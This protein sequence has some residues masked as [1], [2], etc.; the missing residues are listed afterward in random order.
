MLSFHISIFLFQ[1]D[2][3]ETSKLQ[4]LVENL[5]KKLTDP[6][7]CIICNRILSCKSAL[8]MHY[9]THTGE[10][11]FKCKICGRAFTTKGNLKTH[12]GVHR[13][14]PPMRMLHQCPV[15]HKQ[16]TNA[17]V[18]QQHIRMHTGELPKDMPGEF[19]GQLPHPGGPG[20]MP[21][22][23]GFPFLPPP[24]GFMPPG[25]R[26]PMM[27]G[28][29]SELRGDMQRAF[30]FDKT[31]RPS[32]EDNRSPDDREY[33]QERDD[34]DD[35]SERGERDDRDER[36]EQADKE[37]EERYVPRRYPHLTEMTEIDKELQEAAHVAADNAKQDYED[38]GDETYPTNSTG[39][40]SPSS[41]RPASPPYTGTPNAYKNHESTNNES[42][43]RSKPEAPPP[44]S[45]T[46]SSSLLALEE[47]VKAIDVASPLMQYGI[48]RAPEQLAEMMHHNQ[49]GPPRSPA[50]SE[51]S[52]N[53]SISPAA[54]SFPM[55][56]P[57]PNFGLPEIFASRPIGFNGF[58]AP[59]MSP[60]SFGSQRS[61]TCNVC[62]KTFACRSALDIHYRSHTKERPYKCDQCD[63]GF[64]TRGNMRQH[65]LTHKNEND[66][67][68]ARY[69]T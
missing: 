65:Q 25:M 63:R 7:E 42:E 22:F 67:Q 17:L 51:G 10:R 2:K 27:P 19:N 62:F 33:E 56:S 39:R 52:G 15:C 68:K 66:S 55:G 60:N 50:V 54:S 12:M 28:M 1:I 37:D 21:G 16:F 11:P 64:S 30:P 35:R 6:N 29:E 18:L 57:A 32:R 24:M 31:D 40:N 20:F 46:Y 3:S 13:S 26:P 45:S 49:S 69:L 14:K 4:A 36:E 48:H 53:N 34:K 61:T 47:R 8:Q 38:S 59:D 41:Q 23:Q 5:D 44:P 43:Q 9:R 58:G